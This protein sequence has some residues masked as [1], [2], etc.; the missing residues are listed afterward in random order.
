MHALLP[1]IDLRENPPKYIFIRADIQ[2]VARFT[3][4]ERMYYHAIPGTTANGLIQ[5]PQY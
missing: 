2:R 5:N 1:V 4:L 3:F